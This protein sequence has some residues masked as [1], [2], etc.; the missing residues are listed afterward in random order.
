MRIFNTILVFTFIYF[1]LAAQ[2]Q[3][4]NI[5]G[6]SAPVI[7]IYDASGSMWGDLNGKTK[8]EVA[9]DVLSRN[10]DDLNPEQSL[11][12]VAYG[13]RSKGD[14]SDVEFL[15]PADNKS[16]K[17]LKDL[18]YE[19]KPLGKTPLAHSA[20][21]VLDD[22]RSKKSRATIIL[23]T[24]G[25]E[26][27]DG[28]LCDVVKNAVENGIDFKLHIVGFGIEDLNV[29]ELKCAAE[30]GG[31]NYYDAADANQLNSVLN[32]SMSEQ[33]EENF[34]NLAI[35]SSKNSERID[36]WIKVKSKQTGED[37][38][39][40][41]T[42]R[43]TA[44]IAIEPG[45]Y[46]VLVSALENTDIQPQLL[47][48]IQV[49]DSELR[50]E[51][52]KFDAGQIAIDTRM[53]DEGW[54]AVVKINLQSDNTPVSGGRTYGKL[55]KY[56]VSPGEYQIKIECLRLNGTNR[57][58]TIENV[59]VQAGETTSV[60]HSFD[61]GIAKIGAIGENGLMDATVNIVDIET[62]KSVGGS[63]TY[64]S[65]SSNPKSYNLTPGKYSVTLV[66]VREFKGEKRNFEMEIKKGEVFER[67]VDFRN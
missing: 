29:S 45:V 4:V 7:F 17:R 31:G 38:A 66:G 12:L 16:H 30:A 3:E 1:S 20:Q 2:N 8:M 57:I 15:L 56:D 53:N 55:Q 27:C 28:K 44:F 50:I 11:G 58:K 13:H 18:L 67:M 19:I 51:H 63:R 47:S 52:V 22:L 39:S 14:C 41:R 23:I 60:V 62:R 64:T 49:T 36:S 65:E 43:D 46:D 5:S 21:L 59:K 25:L 6:N 10:I 42:Y 32:E 54:D 61:Y 40:S 33:L 37:V 34:R 35:V 9:R 24:D 26:S 48:G